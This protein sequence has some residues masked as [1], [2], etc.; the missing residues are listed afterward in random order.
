[1]Q[2]PEPAFL[3][4]LALM[5][6]GAWLDVTQRRLPNWLCLAV[7]L[8]GGIATFMMGESAGLLSA[9]IHMVIALV[10]GM[11]LFRLG[12]IGGGDAKFYAATA[13]WFGLAEALRLLMSVS[14]L[15]LILLIVFVAFKRLSRVLNR[16]ASAQ[17]DFAK[18][19]YGVAIAAGA[20]VAKSGLY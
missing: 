15:G 14:I 20:V 16:Q 19:P 2:P 10:V 4:L 17:G 6:T 5:A 8:A 11:G 1:M 3:V 9:A 18:L 13:L 7:V 12:M